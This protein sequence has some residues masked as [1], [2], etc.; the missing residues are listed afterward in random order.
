MERGG[1]RLAAAAISLDQAAASRIALQKSQ[2]LERRGNAM[3]GRF[4]HTQHGRDVDHGSRTAAVLGNAFDD[5]QRFRHGAAADLGGTT[6][7][8]SAILRRARFLLLPW[9]LGA[10]RCDEAGFGVH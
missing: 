5:G 8:G 7:V 9:R 3:C 2:F 1:A 6:W 4:R 10:R